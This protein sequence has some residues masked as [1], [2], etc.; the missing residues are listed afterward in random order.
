MGNLYFRSRAIWQSDRLAAGR[1][2]HGPAVFRGENRFIRP[3]DQ[4]LDVVSN[5]G[6]R[7]KQ[8]GK[9]PHGDTSALFLQFTGRN[10]KR[11]GWIPAWTD[12]RVVSRREGRTFQSSG[13]Q[14]EFGQRI[15]YDRMEQ[16]QSEAGND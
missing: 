4:S 6:W 11:K 5:A 9:G 7:K 13:S 2:P 15:W 12:D 10:R 8:H 14:Q 3:L 16:R 1:R